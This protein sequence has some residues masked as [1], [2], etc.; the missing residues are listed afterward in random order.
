VSRRLALTHLIQTSAIVAALMLTAANPL[1]GEEPGTPPGTSQQGNNAGD[2]DSV[3]ET[4]LLDSPYI[5][6]DSWVYPA[7]WRLYAL[8]YIDTVF[9]GMRPYTRSSVSNML[10]WKIRIP[11]P[12]PTKL[13][14]FIRHLR[15]K[16]NSMF[17]ALAAL[18]KAKRG[19]SQSTPLSARSAAL[20]CATAFTWVRR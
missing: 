19:S 4:S 8:G 5:P 3:C 7:V 9:L 2:P 12:K 14:Q 15:T 18:I 1:P 16:F 13:M 11:V 6:V 10:G 17:R 20:H